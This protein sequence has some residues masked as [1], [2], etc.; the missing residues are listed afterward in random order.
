ME[1]R[2][3]LVLDL[4]ETLIFAT[5]EPLAR[6]A[7]FTAFQYHIYRRP[8]LDQFLAVCA[9]HYELGVWSSATDGYV[10][11]IAKNI[12]PNSIALHFVWG[13]SK[14]TLRRVI[15]DERGFLDPHDHLSY[16]KPLVKLKRFG[17][18]LARILIVDDTPNKS[19]Q[20]YGN[21]IYPRPWEGTED[22]NELLLLSRY[23]P[24]LADCV[25]V[26]SVEKRSWRSK[27]EM[28]A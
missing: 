11:Q 10:E 4:D 19:R 24:T 20:N 18:P 25:N 2:N 13:R 14:A 27:A 6:A 26:R 15:T 12:I 7:D 23:L 28:L 8:Y 9:Q 3:L 21:A 5:E 1:N 22:D 17:W 16:R